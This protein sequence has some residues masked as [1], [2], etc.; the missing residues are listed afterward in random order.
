LGVI[1]VSNILTVECCGDARAEFLACL[2]LDLSI[3]YLLKRLHLFIL[4]AK[5]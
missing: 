4:S 2:A 5:S 1:G 3:K